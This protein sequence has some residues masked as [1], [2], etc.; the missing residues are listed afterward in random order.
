MHY[1]DAGVAFSA[2]AE[3]EVVDGLND[4]ISSSIFDVSV[5]RH[6]RF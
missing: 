6:E 2:G 4:I 3:A 5:T 1:I